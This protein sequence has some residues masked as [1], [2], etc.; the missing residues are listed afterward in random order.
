MQSSPPQTPGLYPGP[1]Q[2]SLLKG[3]QQQWLFQLQRVTSD[4][5]SI[6]VE[7]ERL[8]SAFYPWGVSFH[9]YF[10]DANGN[11]SDPGV[12]KLDV[13]TSDIDA[14]PQYCVLSSLTGGLNASFVG[15]VEVP[16]FW[17]RF[18]RVELTTV[19]NPVYT[20]VLVTR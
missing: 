12:F 5:A 17:A 13:E 8:K 1:G 11:P 18:T 9:V 2:A 19:T 10:T 16:S 3:N 7:L 20:S 14:D 15:R 4:Q 6:A